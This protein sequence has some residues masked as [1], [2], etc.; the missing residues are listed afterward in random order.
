MKGLLRTREFYSILISLTVIF[1]AMIYLV[2]VE[3]NPWGVAIITVLLVGCSQ[4]WIIYHHRRRERQARH[5]A[6][7]EIQLMLKDQINSQLTVIQSMSNLRD[8]RQEEAHQARD[9]ITRSVNSISA[10]LNELSEDSLLSWQRRYRVSAR[11]KPLPL[12]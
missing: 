11:Q 7:T 4:G 5:D 3:T 8:I 6:I 12:D 1:L 2:P 10:A 9:Y